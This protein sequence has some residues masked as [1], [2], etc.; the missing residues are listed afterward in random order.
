MPATI[1]CFINQKGGCGISS[2]C[3]HLGGEFAAAGQRVLLVDA[4]PQGSLSQ[5]FLGPALIELLSVQ[6]TLAACFADEH[7]PN[8]LD[9][10]I[11][12]TGFQRLDIICANQTLA[13]YNAPCPEQSGLAQ[14][15]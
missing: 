6:E 5:G 9:R 3:F 10:L 12:P 4:D 1:I 2:C 11:R 7:R 13:A 15:A 14:F 8:T